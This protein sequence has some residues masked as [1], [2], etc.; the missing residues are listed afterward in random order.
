MPLIYG[1]FFLSPRLRDTN[2]NIQGEEKLIN[3]TIYSL[4]GTQDLEATCFASKEDV[5]II[6]SQDS[7]NAQTI[8]FRPGRLKFLTLFLSISD[9]P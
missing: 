5:E 2:T 4:G 9:S 7:A 6:F 1:G 8:R 3:V